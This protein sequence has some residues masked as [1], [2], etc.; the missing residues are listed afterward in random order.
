MDFQSG[1]ISPL[2]PEVGPLGSR[3]QK[4]DSMSIF[5][6]NARAMEMMMLPS[7]ASHTSDDFKKDLVVNLS[8]T[9]IKSE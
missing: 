6:K 3:G 1:Q 5:I 7:I 4:R 9:K 2:T 8:E